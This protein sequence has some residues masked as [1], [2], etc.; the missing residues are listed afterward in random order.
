MADRV[1]PVIL[2]MLSKKLLLDM[3]KHFT[4]RE[5]YRTFYALNQRFRSIVDGLSDLYLSMIDHECH[6]PL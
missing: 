5:L 6:D 2:E 4:A 1:G 3:C